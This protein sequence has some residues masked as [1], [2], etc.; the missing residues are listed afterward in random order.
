[1]DFFCIINDT[2][3]LL[4]NSIKICITTPG[5]IGVGLIFGLINKWLALI[6]YIIIIVLFLYFYLFQSI[7]ELPEATT[8]TSI[9][10][11][12]IILL[13]S[14]PLYFLID[15][16]N[17]EGLQ[18]IFLAFFISSFIKKQYFISISFLA[19]AFCMKPFA[20][21]FLILF[22]DKDRYQ[23][24]GLFI[25]ET[26][27]FTLLA[28]Q[29][30]PGSFKDNFYTVLIGLKY[31]DIF[32]VSGSVGDRFNHTLYT[33]IKSL[34]MLF[35]MF[36]PNHIKSIYFIIMCLLFLSVAAF[37]TKYEFVLWRKIFILYLCMIGLPF[38]SCAYTLIHLYVPTMLFIKSEKLSQDPIIKK[39]NVHITIILGLLMIPKEYFAGFNNSLG[40]SVFINPVLIYILLFKLI[41]FGLYEKRKLK[42]VV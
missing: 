3:E 14:F 20:I 1:M 23:Y 15:R 13:T 19:L 9:L 11:A 35:G 4:N 25:I 42:T 40:I 6:I 39:Y 32:W 31:Y 37:I 10:T 30:I 34:N 36:N 26:I 27:V 17:L 7:K 38:I 22:I 2:H 28:F 5:Y 8:K 12:S 33:P 29:L 18:F 41:S 21:V 24:I 16:G